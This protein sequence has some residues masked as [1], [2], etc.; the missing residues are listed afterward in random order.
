MKGQGATEYLVLL[1]VV[2][3]IALVSI[4]L[5]GFF[6]GTASDSQIAESQIYWK[7]ASPLAIVDT[8]GAFSNVSNPGY[9]FVYLRIRNT[10]QYSIRLNQMLAHG[11]KINRYYD[12]VAATYKFMNNIYIAPGE[13]ACLS[14]VNLPYCQEHTIAFTAYNPGQSSQETLTAATSMCDSS[15]QGTLLLKDVGFNYTV[16]VEGASIVK[17][18]IGAKDLIIKCAGM[19]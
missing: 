11:E 13:E 10:G 5:L 18:F 8:S 7:S 14:G 15:G 9:N 19:Q 3:I 6:P 17:S 1:A 12:N 16:Y 2:L 4:A